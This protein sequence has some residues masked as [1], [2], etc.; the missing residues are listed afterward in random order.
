MVKTI[1]IAYVPGDGSGP[2]MMAQAS[3]IAIEAAKKDSISI[4]FIETPMG[5]NAYEKFG[6]TLPEESFKKASELGLIFFGGVGDFKHDSTIGIRKP[7]LKPET[8]VL[9]AIRKSL[10]LLINIRPITFYK[11]LDHLANV[12][13][14][15]IPE[16]GITQIWVRYLLEDS[17][18]GNPD[19][20]PF[21]PIDVI[22]NI[23]IK[24]KKDITG[25]EEIVTDLAYYKKSTL[26]K[27]LRYAMSLARDLKLPFISI[28]KANV[29]PR[30]DYWRK[31]TEQI[32][33]AEFP[34]IKVISQLVDS[35]NALLFTP[36]KL[37]GV[38]A[39]GNEHGDILSDGAASAVGSMG[40]MCS[41]SIN[42]D[43]KAAFFES[44]AGTAPTIAGQ[45]KANPLGRIL[46]AALMLR[47]IGAIS[48]AAAIEN[49]VN[50]TLH[51][52]FRTCDIITSTDDVSKL[53]GTSAMGK[54]VLSNL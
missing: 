52:G 41:S 7:E 3:V 44:G 49:A 10:G 15:A 4:E 43:T 47:H 2:E 21:I 39:C 11:S 26:E 29:M 22:N 25:K 30:Y 35:A 33:K 6:D 13:E 42:P 12:K 40:M 45:D 31:I 17:Y 34:E 24:L 51:D 9:L 1:K 54:K 14:S 48:G 8:R 18:F 32:A 36:S 50:K 27:Y 28:D 19:L 5:W 23:G 38:I 53:L 37:H 46:T 20:I 16:E